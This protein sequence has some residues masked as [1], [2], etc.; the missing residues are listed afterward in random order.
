MTR[1]V[2]IR[3]CE[4]EG[5]LNRVFQGHTDADISEN[6]QLQLDCLSERCRDFSFDALYASP[7]RRAQKTARAAAKHHELPLQ[8][9]E[10]L[11]EING[12]VWEGLPWKN[13]PD[14]YP[15]QA[16]HWNLSPWD[17]HPDRGESMRALYN[18]IWNAV[19]TIAQRHT[20]QTVCVVSH[21]CAIRNFLCRAHG[22][23]IERLNDVAW[24]DNTA[25]S[26]I[27]FDDNSSPTL[28]L[29]NDSAHLTGDLSTLGKQSWWRP[30]ARA[31]MFF[32]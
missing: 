12:G 8:L 25:L 20:G 30:E 32:E 21:G 22:F 4:A 27:D 16:R 13:L 11:M 9:D 6:G 28:V 19:T 17:F 1:I 31:A 26:I 18:R 14:L 23:P 3:H 24:C 7:L 15:E 5:N 10:H 2:L 29:E